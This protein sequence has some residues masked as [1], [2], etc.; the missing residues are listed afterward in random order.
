MERWHRNHILN[1]QK[2]RDHLCLQQ[3]RFWDKEKEQSQ[4]KRKLLGKLD[5][6]TGEMVPTRPCKKDEP[7]WFFPKVLLFESD[8]HCGPSLVFI[9]CFL[10]FSRRDVPYRLEKPPV[11]K[12]IHPLKRCK[13]HVLKVTPWTASSDNFRFVQPY[14]RFG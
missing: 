13:L 5:P 11:V 1:K 12:P 8:N 6:D 10:K 4:A 7:P 14:D 3:R 2:N 9:E